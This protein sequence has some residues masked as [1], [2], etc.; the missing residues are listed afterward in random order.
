MADDLAQDDS[1]PKNV[2]VNVKRKTVFYTAAIVVLLLGGMGV[3]LAGGQGRQFNTNLVGGGVLVIVIVLIFQVKQIGITVKHVALIEKLQETQATLHAKQSRIE[4]DLEVA[5]RVLQG[6]L[7][8]RCPPM[9]QYAVAARCD[10]A[11][12]IGG[13]F[14]VFVDKEVQGVESSDAEGEKGIL[15][16]VIGDVAGHGVSSALVMALSSGL[17]GQI[18]RNIHSPAIVLTQINKTLKSYIKDS[19]ISFVTA[20][21]AEL[22]KATGTLRMAKAGHH[23]PVV[24]RRAEG[25]CEMVEAPGVFLGMF[26]DPYED[27]EVKL[28]P[29]DRIVFYTDGVTDAMNASGEFFGEEALKEVIRNSREAPAEALVSAIFRSV[30]EF[31]G[32]KAPEDDRTVMVLDMLA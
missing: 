18:T 5:R 8:A 24:Y 29:G 21:Y 16:L 30:G 12:Q 22:D 6:L 23:N 27:R 15:G 2:Q 3:L 7:P 14:Y 31:S 25:L 1:P 9:E 13:D 28:H 19:D 4:M 10:P 11:Y 26:D 20:I 17:F 32:G